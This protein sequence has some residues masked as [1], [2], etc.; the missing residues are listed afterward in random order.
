LK[1]SL[2]CFQILLLSDV[3]IDY[4]DCCVFHWEALEPGYNTAIQG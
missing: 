1:L 4:F 3:S 2:N